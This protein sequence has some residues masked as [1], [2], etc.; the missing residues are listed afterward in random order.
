MAS[1][2][3]NNFDMQVELLLIET[4]KQQK[5]ANYDLQHAKCVFSNMLDN[6]RH[7]TF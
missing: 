5:T 6:V 3:I 2:Q 4:C 1:L 7:V